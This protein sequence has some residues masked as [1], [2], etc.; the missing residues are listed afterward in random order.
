[1]WF[2]TS[3]LSPH[4]L[5]LQF[6]CVLSI[7]ALI[8]LVFMALY[9]YYYYYHYYFIP[10]F[11]W[12]SITGVWVSSSF[13]GTPQGILA[14]LNNAVVRIVSI[15]HLISNSFCLFPYYLGTVPCTSTII[16]ITVIF[17]SHIFSGKIQLFVYFS[18]SFIFALMVCWYNYFFTYCLFFKPALA[19]GVTYW[20]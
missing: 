11:N 7:F 16:G 13:L 17:K 1:M 12:W 15:L 10:R 8:Q 14:D 6:C 3:S 18:L 9:Y 19:G 2:I 5:C 4:N 20:P